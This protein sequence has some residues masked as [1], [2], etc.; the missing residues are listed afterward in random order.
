MSIENKLNVQY[1]K[2]I[3]FKSNVSFP[4]N[5]YDLK[6]KQPTKLNENIAKHPVWPSHFNRL[7]ALEYSRSVSL[8]QLESVYTR[9]SS[10][11]NEN[12]LR[13]AFSAKAHISIH[14]N[15]SLR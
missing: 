7:S 2:Q 1:V 13:D 3:N 9:S 4:L 8:Y 6:P 15:K 12:P 14:P 11:K 5:C 10:V